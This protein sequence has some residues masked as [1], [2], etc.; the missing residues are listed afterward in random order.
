MP[1]SFRDVLG[2]G[3]A[4]AVAFVVVRRLAAL[5]GWTG[6]A[7]E[8]WTESIVAGIIFGIAFA[9][10][11]LAWRAFCQGREPED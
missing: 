4:T 9:L 1:T 11:T 2:Q 10:I 3:A 7:D 6:A 5:L 8:S